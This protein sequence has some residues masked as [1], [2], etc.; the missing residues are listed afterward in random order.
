MKKLAGTII[1]I[2]YFWVLELWGTY[3][4]CTELAKMFA[5]VFLIRCYRK[6]RTNFLAN[7]VF[8]LYLLKGPKFR[9]WKCHKL[10]PCRL[11]MAVAQ[12]GWMR[13]SLQARRPATG[14]PVKDPARGA[15]FLAVNCLSAPVLATH[16]NKTVAP[17][18]RITSSDITSKDWGA[19]EVSLIPLLA[20]GKKVSQEQSRGQQTFPCPTV[21]RRRALSL[22]KGRQELRRPLGQG[23]KALPR[24]SLGAP[25][26]AGSGAP[27]AV[28]SAFWA[29]YCSLRHTRDL[30]PTRLPLPTDKVPRG[31][32]RVS[33]STLHQPTT[34]LSQE[35]SMSAWWTEF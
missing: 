26:P 28:C 10:T 29:L 16:G 7:P 30:L 15:F 11:P 32:V 1:L 9:R 3:F 33:A 2:I 27:P 5:W 8:F 24:C 21:S 19:E 22:C 20:L 4:L 12:V 6:T 34:G 35:S 18:P 17:A 14:R 31:Q 23:S 25:P 13:V